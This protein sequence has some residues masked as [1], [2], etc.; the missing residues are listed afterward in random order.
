MK[1]HVSLEVS[2][3]VVLDHD[4]TAQA[5]VQVI[6]WQF[7][8][9]P[10]QNFDDLPPALRAAFW[11]KLRDEIEECWFSAALGSAPNATWNWL[12]EEI[13]LGTP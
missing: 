12:L 10:P 4:D 3:Q 8:V 6:D 5:D 1:Q 7:D 11:S 9:R 13:D 2:I